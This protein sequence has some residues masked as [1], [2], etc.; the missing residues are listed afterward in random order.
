MKTEKQLERH[1]KGLANH[2]R[3]AVLFL[4]SAETDLSLEKIAKKLEV[5]FHTIA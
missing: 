2:R 3:I 5:N 4:L 1:F